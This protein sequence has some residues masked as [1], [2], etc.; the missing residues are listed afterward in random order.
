MNVRVK[1]DQRLPETGERMKEMG[2]G[3]DGSIRRGRKAKEVEDEQGRTCIQDLF[4]LLT[5]CV[6]VT[7]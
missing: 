3:E 5:A 7:S 1:H 2:W 6:Q 4:Q